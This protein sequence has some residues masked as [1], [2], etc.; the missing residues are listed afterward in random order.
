MSFAV[1]DA[2]EGFLPASDPGKRNRGRFKGIV[3]G[4]SA[5]YYNVIA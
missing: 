1:K 4:A 2:L 3:L 5:V